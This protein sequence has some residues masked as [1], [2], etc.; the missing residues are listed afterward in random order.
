MELDGRVSCTL[1]IRLSFVECRCSH[2]LSCGYIFNA[3]RKPQFQDVGVPPESVQDSIPQ[4]LEHIIVI[5]S[6]QKVEHVESKPLRHFLPCASLSCSL[7]C[8][9]F[10]FLGN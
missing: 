6:K 9:T 4:D 8:S 5:I 7:A 10:G 1:E 2:C 3:Q